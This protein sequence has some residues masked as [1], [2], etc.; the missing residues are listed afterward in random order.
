MVN[1]IHS[2]GNIIIDYITISPR[3]YKI[4]IEPFK[5][6]IHIF[7]VI[8]KRTNNEFQCNNTSIIN[9]ES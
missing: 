7:H 2:L 9:L 5:Y 1:K 8:S 3:K 4:L 6:T